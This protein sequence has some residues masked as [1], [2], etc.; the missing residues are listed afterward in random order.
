[1][2]GADRVIRW[3]TALAVVGV[4]A[5]GAVASYEHACDLVGAHG[6]S[7]WTARMVPFTVDGLIYASSTVMLDCARRE[8][9][10]PVVL[11]WLLGLGIGATP[12][13]NVTHCRGHGLVGAGWLRG[14]RWRWLGRTSYSW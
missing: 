5:V 4:A 7:G 3:S 12:A 13:A 9:P 2:S 1:M 11:R 14:R 10:V 8:T 6:E